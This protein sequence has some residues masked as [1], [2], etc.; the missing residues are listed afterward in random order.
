MRPRIN[1]ASC[2]ERH[3]T[4]I[5]RSMIRIRV[6]AQ[7]FWFGA[8]NDKFTVWVLTSPFRLRAAV[9]VVIEEFASASQFPL[10]LDAFFAGVLEY[11]F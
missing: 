3:N 11:L 4:S 1:L 7:E 8:R 10:F 9:E 6:S 2:Q 5:V